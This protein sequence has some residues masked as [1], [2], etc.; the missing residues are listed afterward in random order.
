LTIVKGAFNGKVVDVGVKDGGHLGLLDWADAPLGV[1]D[2]DGD[3]LLAAQTVDGG[4]AG[5]ATC[6]TN[7]SEMM[8]VL[9]CLTLIAPHEEILEEVS[10]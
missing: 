9:A 8:P 4:G 1:Q 5:V 10:E 7:D 6:R 2:E 3:I